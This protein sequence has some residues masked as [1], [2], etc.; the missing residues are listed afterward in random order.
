MSTVSQKKISH[1]DD[2][3]KSIIN[4]RVI[5]YQGLQRIIINQE[6][7]VENILPMKDD[8][9]TDRQVLDVQGDWIS[10]GGVDLQINGGL[11]LAFPDLEAKH[12]HKLKEICQYLWKQGI[13]GF[14][15]TIVTTPVEKIRRS[16][17][18]IAEV[19]KGIT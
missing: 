8:R 1:R 16:L 18:V 9:S 4:S 2:F 13:D 19:M 17:S 5:G 7:I 10:L 11:G 6:G 15:P 12:R 3:S 14:L